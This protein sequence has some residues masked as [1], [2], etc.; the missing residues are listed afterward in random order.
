[1]YCPFGFFQE[2]LPFFC[3]LR[4][5]FRHFQYAFNA[6]DTFVDGS[7]CYTQDLAAR[8]AVWLLNISG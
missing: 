2:I 5:G 1:M 6:L 8:A 4:C 3:K 7:I